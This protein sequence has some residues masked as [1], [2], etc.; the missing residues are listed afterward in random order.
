MKYLLLVFLI[1]TAQAVYV[2]REKDG[3]I[4]GVY[5]NKQPGYAEESLSDDNESVIAFNNMLNAIVSSPV[6][7]S[8]QLR[9]ELSKQEKMRTDIDTYIKG[10]PQEIQDAWAVQSSFKRNDPV[11]DGIASA[12]GMSAQQ[13][14][15]AFS[16]ATTL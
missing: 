16:D 8:L 4:K 7:T 14:D 1:S 13:M 3:R 5:A 10:A 2:Q 12:V 9:K 11:I 15:A 6:V